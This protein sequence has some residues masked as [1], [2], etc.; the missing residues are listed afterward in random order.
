M[1]WIC[2]YPFVGFIQ[3]WSKYKPSSI[4]HPFWVGDM[5]E[6]SRGSRKWKCR[7][8]FAK[9]YKMS[10]ISENAGTVRLSRTYFNHFEDTCNCQT[11][12]S[13]GRRC[14]G[15]SVIV[16]WKGG[17]LHFHMLLD[18]STCFIYYAS[19]QILAHRFDMLGD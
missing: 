9:I 2:E 14:V 5:V 17:K 1:L 19:I 11:T 3:Y 4:E 18:R 8:E 6:M 10:E 12:T 7:W 13:V 16:Y 15:Q